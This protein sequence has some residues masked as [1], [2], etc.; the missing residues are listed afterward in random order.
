MSRLEADED[1]ENTRPEASSDNAASG[2]SSSS[3][4]SASAS[5][6]PS[7]PPA[8]NSFAI[9]VVR[10]KPEPP[11]PFKIIIRD[12]TEENRQR[13]ANC[14]QCKRPPLGQPIPSTCAHPNAEEMR[15][16]HTKCELRY[17]KKLLHAGAQPF[18]RRGLVNAISR[19]P[20]RFGAVIGYWQG[21]DQ[22]FWKVFRAQWRRWQ[23]FRVW[24]TQM[25]EAFKYAWHL[26]I[27]RV[28]NLLRSIRYRGPR[29]TLNRFRDK[30][31][32]VA[33]WVE[34][35]AY[36]VTRYEEVSWY[37]GAR[38]QWDM[39]DRYWQLLVW[40]NVLTPTDCRAVHE[41]A[42]GKR[43]REGIKR[44]AF[45]KIQE[46]ST[47]LLAAQRD[48]MDPMLD[49][50][51]REKAVEIREKMEAELQD[52]CD[53]HQKI[54]RWDK[55]IEE[56]CVRTS[57][58]RMTRREGLKQEEFLRWVQCQSPFVRTRF[59]RDKGLGM[60]TRPVIGQ[61]KRKAEGDP[62]FDPEEVDPVI[63]RVARL[64]VKRSCELS[65]KNQTAWV[66]R[67]MRAAKAKCLK[68][69]SLGKF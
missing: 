51:G 22:S 6:S 52:T 44:Q 19:N 1:K 32:P 20:E 56:Y 41:T 21:E 2:G 4:A 53:R 36:E 40:T 66:P 69:L 46:S 47:N 35:L 58:Y 33:T 55:A 38:I 15:V 29:V 11:N 54:S 28:C 13:A 23:A 62:E 63:G 68:E 45:L 10:P 64:P 37:R 43:E 12:T 30:Q 25:R 16:W 49:E 65:V 17:A 67:P 3:A 61:E 27:V 9:L 59:R 31:D 14:W 24:Q 7:G 60:L 34:Y 48:E 39:Y 42:Q 57:E 5:S 26:F 18:Y 50:E 8:P